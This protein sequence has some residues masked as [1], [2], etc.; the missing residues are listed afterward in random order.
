[1]SRPLRI[2]YPNAF[3]HVMNRGLGR[4]RIYLIDDDYGMFL[5]ALQ[6]SSKLYNLRVIAFCLM[7]NHYHLLVQT[8]KANLSRAM[9]HL[10]GVY[11]QRFNRIHKSDGPLFRGRYKAILIQEDEYLTHLIRY[12]HLNPLQANLVQSPL[13]YPWSSHKNYL[14]GKDESQWL[15]TCLGLS[16]FASR[17][18]TAIRAYR[19][20]LEGGIDPR[21]RAFYYNKKQNPIF[22]DPDFI[23][24]VRE[25]YVLGNQKLSSEVPEK[26]IY[27]GQRMAD[28]IAKEAAR[29]FGVPLQSLGRSRRGQTNHARLAAINLTRELSGL[30]LSEI[31][32][33]YGMDSYKSVAASCHRLKTR[34]KTERDLNRRYISLLNAC[35][36]EET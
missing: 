25:K 19:K 23:E 7:P 16:F 14:K 21:T 35:S 29:V 4:Q 22:G 2:E 20:F 36:Q 18:K 15:H 26:R 32:Q 28:K 24:L 13:K 6:E 12:I 11:T 34:L 27:E 5:D 9:R 33:C 10:N 31:A 8:P 17:L 1:M 30:K 3:Y